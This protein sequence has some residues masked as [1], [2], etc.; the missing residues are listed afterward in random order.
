MEG[1]QIKQIEVTKTGRQEKP[2][3]HEPQHTGA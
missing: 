1:Y 2:S 3:H